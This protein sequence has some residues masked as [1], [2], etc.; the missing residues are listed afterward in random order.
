MLKE[1]LTF[2][3]TEEKN[4]QNTLNAFAFHSETEH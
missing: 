3:V 2:P 1:A 4:F